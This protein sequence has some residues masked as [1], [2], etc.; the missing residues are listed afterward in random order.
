MFQFAMPWL[1]IL[2]PL[3]WVVYH[4]VKAAKQRRTAA[5]IV[6]FYE[7]VTQMLQDEAPLQRLSYRRYLAYLAWVLLV[8][9]AA[10]PEWLGKPVV[11][12]QSGR[13]IML[14]LDLSR[15]MERPDMRLHGEKTDRITVVKSV[16][17]GFIQRRKGDR[18]G[19]IL[20]GTRA[21]LQTPLTFDRKTVKHMLNDASIGLAGNQTAIGDAIGLGIKRLKAVSAKSRVL[22]LLTDGVNNA[23]VVKPL[24][25]AKIAAENHIKIYTIGLGA[26]RLVIPGLFGQQLMYP[27]S[28]LDIESLKKIAKKTGGL[29]FRATNTKDL[30]KIYR[31]I[32]KLEP[33]VRNK[34]TYRPITTYYYVPLLLVLLISFYL[35]GC[36]C[37]WISRVDHHD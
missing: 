15:S 35:A 1:F 5:L 3:P 36:L 20:F 24:T 6:P 14:A 9:A 30:E 18:L 29:F 25:A 28:D 12:P 34:T 33:I 8:I 13:D 23:G 19:L 16:A 7:S 27:S 11:L 4:I 37:T 22:V 21:Y 31:K 32:D 2:L 17:R 26:N 10:G